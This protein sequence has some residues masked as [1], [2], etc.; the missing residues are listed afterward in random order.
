MN[1]EHKKLIETITKLDELPSGEQDY[2]AWIQAEAHLDFLR[3]NA[4]ANELA[5]YASGEYTVIHSIVVPSDRLTQ[6]DR[7][8]LMGWSSGPRTSI[9]SYVSGGGRDDVW[10]ER[11]FS[12][13]S[14][15]QLIFCRTF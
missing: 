3:T 15:M 10:V 12:G 7:D 11:D 8:E 6:V 4:R 5:I 2:A 14:T 1:Y 13:T 9:A